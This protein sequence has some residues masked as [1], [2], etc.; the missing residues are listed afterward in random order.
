LVKFQK[1]NGILQGE[2]LENLEFIYPQF[3]IMFALPLIWLTYTLITKKRVEQT[4]FAPEILKK[5]TSSSGGISNKT[6]TIIALFSLL[7]MVT[8]LAR[9]V[10]KEGSVEVESHST[11]LLFALDISTSMLATDKYPNRLE[12]SKKKI[13]DIIKGLNQNRVGVI[14]FANNGYTVAPMSFDKSGVSYL[15]QN[16]HSQ[17]ISEQGTSIQQLLYSADMFLQDNPDRVLLIFTDGGDSSDYSSEIAFAREK[18]MRIFIIGIGSESGSPIP[19]EDGSLLKVDGNIVIS[20]FNS[21]IKDLALDT[22]GIFMNGVNSDEDVK[23]ILSEILKIDSNEIKKDEIPI[24]MELFI[25]PLLF[26]LA[27]LF[28]LLYSLPTVKFKRFWAIVTLIVLSQPQNIEAGL[29]DWLYIDRAE[30]NINSGEYG[31]AIEE[32]SKLESSDEVNFNIGNAHYHSGDYDKA[33]ESYKKVDG[34]LKQQALYNSGNSLV[35]KGELER[36]KATYEKALTLGENPKVRENLEWVKNRLQQNKQNQQDNQQQNRDGENSENQQKQNSDQNQSQDGESQQEQN[37]KDGQQQSQESKDD[38]QKDGE[39]SEEK[40]DRVQKDGQT[41]EQQNLNRSES[42]QNEQG[43]D[44]GT[45]EDRVMRAGDENLSEEIDVNQSQI[46]IPSQQELK[47]V[48]NMEEKKI[49]DMLNRTKG[50]TKIY[51]I[52]LSDVPE[53]RENVKP[54]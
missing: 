48:P 41:E 38:S 32:L 27:L 31:K 22:G 33:I 14:A 3:F 13:V 54:W 16:L 44:N 40:S 42:H 36:A 7:F 53:R 21:A 24:Y 26:A 12:F 9:P 46:S 25:Y 20:K 1:I 45:K 51:S 39:D 28:P 49:L 10:I 37:E 17:N 52:P 47:E 8:A 15:V 23:A 18:G 34:E 35:Q 6:R 29:L 2:S 19:L 50:G 5:L 11:D 4:I 43:E 30:E